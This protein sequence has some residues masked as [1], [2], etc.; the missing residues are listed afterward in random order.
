MNALVA[1][2]MARRGYARI[3]DRDQFTEAWEQASGR[4]ASQSRAGNIRR[5]TLEIV[6]RNSLIL[7]ELTFQKQQL[8]RTMQSLLPDQSIR[9][10][11]FSVGNL[12]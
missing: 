7:Q 1:M 8:L 3:L 10:L 11:R 4:L 2:L 6:V 5:G 12:D 9:D